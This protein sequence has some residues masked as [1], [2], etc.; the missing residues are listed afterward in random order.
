MGVRDRVMSTD[1]IT[2]RDVTE[3]DFDVLFEHQRDPDA[4]YMA[5]Y[6]PRDREEFDA[7]TRGL[8][9]RSD[10]IKQV[11][12]CGDE[13]VGSIGCYLRGERR[14]IG[15]W[16]DREFWG[17]GIATRALQAMLE[18]VSDRPL[19]AF[20]AVRN[21]ASVRVLEKCGFV[22]EAECRS[23]TQDHWY[24]VDEYLYVLM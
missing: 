4:A 10:V 23:P 22:R 6:T 8:L 12:L 19:H 18:R 16:I 2:L 9:A 7:H 11:I 5:A 1:P 13:V 24:E 14:L 21:A 17:K 3:D 20:V 15:Y